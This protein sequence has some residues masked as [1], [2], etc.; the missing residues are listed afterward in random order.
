MTDLLPAE[1]GATA[2]PQPARHW[3][4]AAAEGRAGRTG[5]IA[6][7]VEDCMGVAEMSASEVRA[8]RRLG[9]AA[10]LAD[11]TPGDEVEGQLTAQLLMVHGM[12]MDCVRA[13]RDTVK[14]ERVR[15]AYLTHAARM[16]SLYA[17]HVGKLEQ[18]RDLAGQRARAKLARTEDALIA[19][20]MSG[21]LDRFR[22]GTGVAAAGEEQEA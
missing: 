14:E 16:V 8:D 10:A 22:A 15:L 19:A 11:I 7:E 6:R 21:T 5:R 4:E 9:V 12:A 20:A 2:A 1:T 3:K 17:R 18:R 13:A